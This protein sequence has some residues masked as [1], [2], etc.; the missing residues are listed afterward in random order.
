MLMHSALN[1][2]AQDLER[3]TAVRKH[4][5]RICTILISTF[6]SS[7]MMAQSLPKFSKF[8]DLNLAH[9][10]IEIISICNLGISGLLWNPSYPIFLPHRPRTSYYSN[11]C[12]SANL[13]L[14]CIVCSLFFQVEYDFNFDV[15]TKVC[16]F[17]EFAFITFSLFIMATSLPCSYQI[18][19]LT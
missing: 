2:S 11:L 9:M 7:L 3:G 5:A 8:D 18:S 15:L 16:F 17:I 10:K 12:F 4:S 1:I 19:Y 14:P 6:R 13:S